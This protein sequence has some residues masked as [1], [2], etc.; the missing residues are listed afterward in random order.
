MTC[1][2]SLPN[3]WYSP[4]FPPST[5][6]LW[7]VDIGSMK[8]RSHTASRVSALSTSAYGG[9]VG[10]STPPTS[11]RRGPSSPMCSQIEAEPGPP[12]K[13]KAIGRWVTSAPS[14]RSRVYAV[15]DS[16]ARAFQPVNFSFLTSSSRSTMRP[17]R[18]V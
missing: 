8:T 7:P 6:R 4:A 17:V 15:T 18:A 3:P 5:A 11:T 2:T 10:A 9:G 13:T 12:L 1:S 16:S 14:A